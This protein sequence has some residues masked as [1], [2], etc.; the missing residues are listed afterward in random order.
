MHCPRDC[1]LSAG[2]TLDSESK[3]SQVG[4][5]G[6]PHE[7]SLPGKK[8]G[9]PRVLPPPQATV[10][11]HTVLPN[12]FQPQLPNAI[13]CGYRQLYQAD[14]VHIHFTEEENSS[15]QRPDSQLSTPGCP[16]Q[17]PQPQ[18]SGSHDVFPSDINSVFLR[19]F[20]SRPL[21]SRGQLFPTHHHV[22]NRKLSIPNLE[23]SKSEQGIEDTCLKSRS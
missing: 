20:H 8:A 7:L 9:L 12:V 22:I 1:P 5:I 14:G 16:V 2:Y 6:L 21:S 11:T 15:S 10:P 3:Y 13:L 23:M 18:H 4:G 17:L 19:C